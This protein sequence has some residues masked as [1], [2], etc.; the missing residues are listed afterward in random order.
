MILSMRKI[1]ANFKIRAGISRFQIQWQVVTRPEFGK[2]L[3]RVSKVLKFAG[4]A[5][6]N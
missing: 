2:L 1:P 3:R 4:I 6:L 5:L